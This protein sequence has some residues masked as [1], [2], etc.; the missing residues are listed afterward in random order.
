M[1]WAII[2]KWIKRLTCYLFKVWLFWKKV[3]IFRKNLKIDNYSYRIKNKKRQ[4]EELK[5]RR[6]N[7]VCLR[8]FLGKFIQSTPIKPTISIDRGNFFSGA[9]WWSKAQLK[10]WMCFK[11][12]QRDWMLCKKDSGMVNFWF[13]EV[14]P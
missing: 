9:K 12:V 6:K 10:S 5:Y 7:I 1:K 8:S 3:T 11:R 14:P 2:D 13:L 4:N